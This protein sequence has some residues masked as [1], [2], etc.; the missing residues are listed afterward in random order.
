MVMGQLVHNDIVDDGDDGGG[1]KD[2]ERNDGVVLY[3][4]RLIE[5]MFEC[6]QSGGCVRLS[7]KGPSAPGTKQCYHIRVLLNA[8]VS[9]CGYPWGQRGKE[10]RTVK[11]TRIHVGVVLSG[12]MDY[13]Q[14]VSPPAPQVQF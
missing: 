8:T 1:A 7:W 9:P 11:A 2:D 14:D 3:G 5:H 4:R 12:R 10:H 6:F 13:C